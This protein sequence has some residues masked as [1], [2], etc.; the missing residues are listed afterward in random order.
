MARRL[1][2]E[3]NF[4]EIHQEIFK[5]HQTEMEAMAAE[6]DGEDVN[7]DDWMR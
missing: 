6:D 3:Q 1:K 5:E 7:D 2:F 4:Y